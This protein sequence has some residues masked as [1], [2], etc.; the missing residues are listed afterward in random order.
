[1]NEKSLDKNLANIERELI[2]LQTAHEIGLGAISFYSYTDDFYTFTVS[3]GSG[4]M[5]AAVVMVDVVDG[6]L[7]NPL[8]N[9]YVSSINGNNSSGFTNIEQYSP[10]KYA[11]IATKAFTGA[12]IHM[13]YLVCS[14]SKLSV[15]VASS[16]QDYLDWLN[17]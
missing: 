14:S 13:Y 16:Y 2:N 3:T 11:F 8:L 5:Q 15:S 9:F 6:E 10:R 12:H 17:G 7:T 1:M 4:D